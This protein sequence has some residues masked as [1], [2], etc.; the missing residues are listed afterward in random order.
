MFQKILIAYDGSA[1]SRKA[2]EAALDLAKR[3]QAQIH[4]VAVARPPDF[5]EDVE[6]E[7][8]LESA[9]EHLGRQ[10]GELESQA[11]RAGLKPHF[12]VVTGHPA[13]QIVRAAEQQAIE[14]IV[15]GHRGHG[16]FERWLLGSVSRTVIAYAPCAVMVVR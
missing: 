6:T 3:Y 11:A 1:P 14:L 16:M 9:R 7:A 2:Y 12:R 5:A 15:L 13:E 10:F 8:T 4:V